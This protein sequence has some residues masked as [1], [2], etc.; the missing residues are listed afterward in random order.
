MYLLIPVLSTAGA[1]TRALRVGQLRAIR[2]D[3]APWRRCEE[4]G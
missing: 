1:Q 3:A 2:D 4:T